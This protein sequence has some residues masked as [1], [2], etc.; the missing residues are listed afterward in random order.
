MLF[1]ITIQSLSVLTIL[2]GVWRNNDTMLTLYYTVA[3]IC[4][5][6]WHITFSHAGEHCFAPLTS[7]CFNHGNDVRSEYRL[8]SKGNAAILLCNLRTYCEVCWL[9]AVTYWENNWF[10]KRIHWLWKRILCSLK[11]PKHNASF[12]K[13]GK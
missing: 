11:A 3:A 5:I 9:T 2:I 4:S 8:S 10:D 12:T 1:I 13:Y 6:T 7:L